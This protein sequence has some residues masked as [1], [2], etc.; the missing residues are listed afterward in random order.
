[1]SMPSL[2]RAIYAYLSTLP[3][4][5][6]IIG[7]RLYP[8]IAPT[9]A[10][11]PYVTLHEIMIESFYYLRGASATFDAMMQIDCWALEPMQAQHMAKAIRQSMDGLPASWDGLEVDGVFIDSE[12][13]AP[14]PAQD[15]SERAYYRRVM[16][17]NVWHAREV[18]A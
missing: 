3:A 18:P 15:G 14:E 17:V 9:S 10:I 1:M 11:F 13:D 6:A 16:T 8:G 2:P 5:T 4:L 7:T 12:M